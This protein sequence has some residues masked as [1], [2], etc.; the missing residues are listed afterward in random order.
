[1]RKIQKHKNNLLNKRWYT[2]YPPG[3]D[4]P[5]YVYAPQ[6]LVPTLWDALGE[7]G[8]RIALGILSSKSSVIS[9]T[10][11]AQITGIDRKNISKT[12]AES[13]FSTF[14]TVTRGKGKKPTSYTPTAVLQAL[15]DEK[16]RSPFSSDMLL[17]IFLNFKPNQARIVLDLLQL[18]KHDGSA[19]DAFIVPCSDD[20]LAERTGIGKRNIARALDGLPYV[21]LVR[22]EPWTAGADPKPTR[23]DLTEFLEMRTEI[24]LKIKPEEIEI[25]A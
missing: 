6:S 1:M 11:L 4:S 13:A 14:F 5:P 12:V 20:R 16:S 7:R 10:G 24:I 19:P 8:T 9:D 15:L 21:K 23:Y 22:G 17:F 2:L 3:I 25:A 18:T